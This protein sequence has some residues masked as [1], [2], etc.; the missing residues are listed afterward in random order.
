MR[1]TGP[2][3]Q[4]PQQMERAIEYICVVIAGKCLDYRVGLRAWDYSGGAWLPSDHTITGIRPVG[5]SIGGGPP[6]PT[7][8][9]AMQDGSMRHVNGDYVVECGLSAPSQILAI[10]Q[11]PDFLAGK[12]QG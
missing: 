3:G 6:L 11:R 8:Q 2:V 7:Y 1:P 4:G 12:G 10:D 9:I 5:L